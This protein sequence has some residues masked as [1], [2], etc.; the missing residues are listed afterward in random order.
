ML[1]EQFKNI[2]I[3]ILIIAIVLSALLGHRVEAIAISAIMLFAVLLGFVQEYRADRAIEAL[4]KMAAPTA[5]VIRDG[6]EE[7]IPARDLVPGD[8]IFLRAG[9]RVS[10]DARLIEAINLQA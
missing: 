6:E 2:L 8:I 1:G 7:D 5:T 9:D 3:I 4:R 10:A